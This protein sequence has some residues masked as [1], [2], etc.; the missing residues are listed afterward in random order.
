MKQGKK[1]ICVALAF[2]LTT[3]TAW[4]LADAS[5]QAT[6]PGTEQ[7]EESVA[8]EG[9][10]AAPSTSPGPITELAV[11]PTP[12]TEP[13]VSPKPETKPAVSP[14]PETEPAASPAPRTE[15]TVPPQPAQTPPEIPLPNAKSPEAVDGN[16]DHTPN[17]WIQPINEEDDKKE[18]T[19]LRIPEGTT[20]ITEGQFP[21][22]YNYTD[23]IIPSTVTSIGDRAFYRWSTVERVEFEEGSLLQTIGQNAFGE[24]SSLQ[25]LE[26]PDSVQTIGSGSFGSCTA[27]VEITLPSGLETI[28]DNCFSSCTNLSQVEIPN[29]VTELGRFAFYDC[30]GLSQ[31]TFPEN[32]QTIGM[33]CFSMAGLTSVRIPDGV[34]AI[35]DRAFE[36]CKN[37]ETAVFPENLTE[38]SASV[39]SGCQKLSAFVIPAKVTT[40]QQSAF[41]QCA[42]LKEMSIPDLTTNLASGIFNSCTGLEKIHIGSGVTNVDF[43][44]M[45]WGC[46]SLL[47]ITVSEENRIYESDGNGVVFQKDN[48]S[49]IYYPP[50]RQDTS[51]TVPDYVKTIAEKA[52]YGHKW[53]AEIDFQEGIET[54]GEN[55]F[56]ECTTLEKAELPQSLKKIGA[57]AFYKCSALSKITI[58]SGVTTLGNGAFAENTSL[59]EAVLEGNIKTM[60]NAVFMGCDKLKHVSFS[61]QITK[62]PASMFWNCSALQEIQIPDS[63]KTIGDNAFRGSGLT[64]IKIP[65]SITSLGMYLFADCTGLETVELQN[66][67]STIGACMFQNCSK[68]GSIVIPDTVTSVGSNAFQDCIKLQEIEIPNPNA[69]VETECFKGCTALKSLKLPANLKGIPVGL[70]ENCE[71]LENLKLPE[72]ITEIERNAFSGCKSLTEVTVPEKVNQISSSA[73]LNCTGLTRVQLSGTLEA[74]DYEVFSGCTSLEEIQLPEGLKTISSSVFENCQKLETIGIPDTVTSIFAAAFS[75]CSS[76]RKIVIPEGVTS[77][78]NNFNGCTELAQVTVKGSATKLSDPLFQNCPKLATICGPSG[79]YAEEYA[80][81]KGISF[82]PIG[83]AGSPVIT[84]VDTGSLITGSGIKL[85][86]EA[87]VQVQMS[88]EFPYDYV[89]A[90]YS[91]DQRAYTSLGTKDKTDVGFYQFNIDVTAPEHDKLWFRVTGYRG[92][93]AG[94]PMSVMMTLDHVP[95]DRPQN[96]TAAAEAEYIYLNW[97]NL[98]VEENFQYYLIYRSLSP[99]K[100][101]EVLEAMST[102]GY[103]DYEVEPGVTYYYYMEALDSW[104]NYS[105]STPVRSAKYVDS[106]PPVIEDYL[107]RTDAV[108]Y[109]NIPV[110]V[111][112]YDNYGVKT[113]ALSYRI[114]GQTDWNPVVSLTA[115]GEREQ[116][117]YWYYDWDITDF[118]NGTYEMKIE[119]TDLNGLAAEPVV[120]EYAVMKYHTPPD[121]SLTAKGGHRS[122]SLSWNKDPKDPIL[123]NYIIYRTGEQGNKIRIL[124]T[125][126]DSY[127]D[128]VAPGR[129][130]YQVAYRNIFGEEVYSR[131]VTADA[132]VNDTE[133]PQ[134]MI[135]LRNPSGIPG[136]ALTFDGSGS[137]DNDAIASYY[138][139]FG[140]H[141]VS[142]QAVAAHTF[143]KAG[144]YQVKL[145]V[146]DAAGNEG[147]DTVEVKVQQPDAA[148][149][150]RLVTVK[151][152]DGQSGEGIEGAQILLSKQGA[153]EEEQIAVKADTTG[154]ATLV[155]DADSVYQMAALKENSEYA[156]QDKTIE[157]GA[158]Q[159]DPEPQ[160][161]EIRLSRLHYLIGDVTS[162]EMTA[163]EIKDAGIDINDPANRNSYEFKLTLEYE[164]AGQK[165]SLPVTYYANRHAGG[166]SAGGQPIA[167]GNESS[168]GTGGS[169]GSGTWISSGG[170]WLV[171]LG[172]TESQ[173]YF[174]ILNGTVGW[175]KQMYEVSLVVAN[176]SPDDWVEDCSA[177]IKL[178]E[179]LA[180]AGMN[181]D[182][183][184][185]TVPVG[186]IGKESQI[187]QTWYVRGDK[188]GSYPIQVEVTG[189]YYPEPAEPF[190]VVYAT[191][192]PLEVVDTS[193]ALE[194]TVS[195]VPREIVSGETY[196]L[197]FTLRNITDAALNF[198]TLE[199]NGGGNHKKFDKE[200]I[201]PG[202]SV[203]FEYDTTMHFDNLKDGVEMVLR[204]MVLV[205]GSGLIPKIEFK[206]DDFPGKSELE[207]SL[208]FYGDEDLKKE[209]KS[210]VFSQG[211]FQ[212]EKEE[213]DDTDYDCL[214]MYAA[215]TNKRTVEG[216]AK[217]ATNV[218]VKIEA[219]EGFSFEPYKRKDT[220]EYSIPSLKVGEISEPKKIDLYPIFVEPSDSLPDVTFRI[221]L[222]SDVHTQIDSD[223]KLEVTQRANTGTIPFRSTAAVSKVLTGNEPSY[224]SYYKDGFTKNS[225]QYDQGVATLALALSSSV[226]R[227]GDIKEGLLNIGFSDIRGYN[228]SASDTQENQ[229][230]VNRDSV[231][232]VFATKKIFIE[233]QVYTIVAIVIRGTVGE[234][235]YGNFN[236]GTGTEHYSFRNAYTDVMMRLNQYMNEREIP[237]DQTKL[238]ITG[239]SRGAATANLLAADLDGSEKYAAA[240][241]IYAYTFAT[242]NVTTQPGVHDNRYHNIFNILNDADFV[243]YVPPYD[244]GFDK[245]GL[246]LSFPKKGSAAYQQ[247]ISLV[248][249]YFQTYTKVA[250]E[251]QD[252]A[253]V[254]LMTWLLTIG[255][256]NSGE[257]ESKTIGSAEFGKLLNLSKLTLS[258]LT[259]SLFIK[260][261]GAIY[262]KGPVTSHDIGNILA[263]MTLGIDP[264]WQK[265]VSYAHAVET[266]LAWMHT[267]HPQAMDFGT[268]PAFKVAAVNCP[269]DVEVYDGQGNLIGKIVDNTVDP[270]ISSDIT[271]MVLGDSK[272]L[273]LPCSQAYQLKLAGNGSGT[274]T[275]T[276]SEYSANGDKLRQ[277]NFYDVPIEPGKIMYGDVNEELGTQIKNYALRSAD[278]KPLKEADEELKGDTLAQLRVA[279]TEVGSG[280]ALGEGQYT[281]GEYAMLQA[282]PDSGNGFYGWYVDGRKVSGEPEYGFVVLENISLEAR[283]L[284]GVKAPE[285]PKV[286]A[287]PGAA[288]NT[289]TLP[290]H[291]TWL[292]PDQKLEEGENEYDAIFTPAPD[293]PTDYSTLEGWDAEHGY[294]VMPVKITVVPKEEPK[295]TP[296]PQPTPEP[297]ASPVPTVE[298]SPTGEPVPTATPE[299]TVKPN[300]PDS[301]NAGS[302]GN[303]SGE[304]SKIAGGQTGDQAPLATLIL[305]ALCAAA[306]VVTILVRRRRKQS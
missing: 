8:G 34:T 60:D 69:T 232:N 38:L 306:A 138:W 19:V 88:D 229:S 219:P 126:A 214:H 193:S 211:S 92:D 293:D 133:A 187:K 266:Y 24:C 242:P 224:W 102:V 141:T 82:V 129:Y 40:I 155:L 191:K 301:S 108:Q 115:E 175:L 279:L 196:P 223:K 281:K 119:V 21:Y 273:Y 20:Q 159:D 86:R 7:T 41:S 256:K 228:F 167:F 124:T 290:D 208:K 275:Y 113:V 132:V 123:E 181:K 277:V 239:H 90:E 199:I 149:H 255:A 99:D 68:L 197:T 116:E 74:L 180:L 192:E 105:E 252:P 198:V 65:G 31:L 295:P 145:T 291:W 292:H 11:S 161:E 16:M 227:Y 271:A 264:K 81:K 179:G 235:W 134:A 231:A 165:Q 45:L 194:L 151:V 98:P 260:A 269:V 73:F 247:D 87:Y 54:I 112:T 50:A 106:V 103:R 249:G 284:E 12:E 26:I 253:G 144:T 25:S 254:R 286:P 237:K 43:Q 172:G 104:G 57:S 226:Y 238:L 257:Y 59:T 218:K 18:E 176:T 64:G 15:T 117:K 32:L 131:E 49:L 280:T 122:V 58:P 241:N 210:L 215:V 47:E 17:I 29:T 230:T 120:A 109:R 195:N 70:A 1:I 212:F 188:A 75:G 101:F 14:A 136:M 2:L 272:I 89:E 283:F 146:T 169:S 304:D 185:A 66:G 22:T 270:T 170:Q 91:Y 171:P 51:Y 221:A 121:V 35:E 190:K 30:E 76:L 158:A 39:F 110:Q 111:Q 263:Y 258:P 204:Q 85:K 36:S 143:Q 125:K 296:T 289:V 62:I 234:E 44:S 297:T 184:S 114:K 209:V 267:E 278:Q 79:S 166:F 182:P 207:A 202:E 46:T 173:Q 56:A 262:N 6:V 83:Q 282:M 42:S 248:A 213:E 201:K 162:R 183:Q 178:P 27:L 33:L 216:N 174:I 233:D 52:F 61:N 147:T 72:S 95:P 152:A 205:C 5:Q 139:E 80:Q 203:S 259:A 261:A 244:W 71:N 287:A 127:V 156:M 3:Q 268:R 303:S 206:P 157:V 135:A 140:D 107:P 148:S 53:L 240:E 154:S 55:A 164:I 153:K 243:T 4:Q 294:L 245:Y 186:T 217:D 300:R 128:N 150:K 142:N 302:G 37:L 78:S 276:L 137:T 118:D 246:T 63:V 10:Q 288:L 220:Y 96:F 48:A 100:D 67:L 23:I 222:S 189:S 160:E 225:Y 163:Q 84:S 168:G 13:A 177:T 250:F 274:M 299:P 97:D 9:Q 93:V 265:S 200:T 94:T 285:I 251:E 28:P 130:T 77:L 298:P 236:I 305:L